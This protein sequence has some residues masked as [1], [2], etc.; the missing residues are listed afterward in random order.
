V[1]DLPID[2]RQHRPDFLDLDVRHREVVSIEH[3]QV[4][5]LAWLDRG[6]SNIKAADGNSPACN[7][8][9]RSKPT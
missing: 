7:P 2:N 3:G 8:Y 5:Q 4:G 6:A 9:M 1:D